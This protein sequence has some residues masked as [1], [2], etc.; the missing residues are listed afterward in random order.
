MKSDKELLAEVI[1]GWRKI[2]SSASRVGLTRYKLGNRLAQ[3]PLCD[4]YLD[5]EC[6]GCPVMRAT[7]RPLCHHTPF[8]KARSN[9][10]DWAKGKVRKSYYLIQRQIDFLDSLHMWEVRRGE[11]TKKL[12]QGPVL[13]SEIQAKYGLSPSK[14]SAWMRS[15]GFVTR[16][17][18]K[19]G[20]KLVWYE[21]Q[22]VNRGRLRPGYKCEACGEIQAVTRQTVMPFVLAC[23]KCGAKS[24]LCAI[25]YHRSITHRI[26]ETKLEKIDESAD[27]GSENPWLHPL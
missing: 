17:S 22:P 14:A 21:R 26:A 6:E 10:I 7:S 18:R 13:S 9:V 3:K 15:L 12:E 8:D 11:I 24:H 1:A 27:S 19:N 16:T 25:D 4:V 2:K 5:G 23:G 20:R